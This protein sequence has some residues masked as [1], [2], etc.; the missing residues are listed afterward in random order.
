MFKRVN[1]RIFNIV[2]VGSGGTPL[3]LIGGWIGSWQLWRQPMELLS[4]HRRCVAYDHRGAGQ[5]V[6]AKQD[7]HPEGLVDDVFLVL[8]ALGIERCWLA[9]ESQGGI[10]AVMAAVRDPS[11]FLGLTLI[12][13]SPAFEQTPE[14]DQFAA[15]L[16]KNPD[17]VLRRFVDLCIPEADSDHLRR[18]LLHILKE[19]EPGAGVSLVRQMYGADI[20]DK[21]AAV[22]LP[23]Q[24]V[25]G[26]ADMIEA[27]AGAATL[28]RGIRNAEL[29]LLPGV[30]HVPTITRPEIVAQA[31]ESF[32]AR[33]QA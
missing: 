3:L 23:T 33:H 30:G 4:A 18:W 14:H 15:A 7:L 9:G 6:A 8:D 17:S 20:R 31:M 16:E 22:S 2:S 19:A 5:T 32:M 11:R 13:T 25:H 12:A 26:E 29:L 10:I 1:G 24:I 21:L 28:A 27:P